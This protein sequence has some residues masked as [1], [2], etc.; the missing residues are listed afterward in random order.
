MMYVDFSVDGKDYKLR[1]NTR[2]IITLEKTLGCNPLAIFGDGSTVPKVTELVQVLHAA[3]QPLNHGI[4]L[5]DSY[6]IFD[7]Y[8]EEHTISDFIKVV[9]DIYKTCGLIQEDNK[10]KNA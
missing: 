4:S 2:G 3:L 9:V 8:L 6:D 10:E 5:E 7:K 1:L